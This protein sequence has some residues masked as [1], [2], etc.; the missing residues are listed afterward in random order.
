[1]ILPRADVRKCVPCVNVGY[2]LT[3]EL[4]AQ[5][6]GNQFTKARQ[7]VV[8]DQAFLP[9]FEGVYARIWSGATIP[10]CPGGSIWPNP[11]PTTPSRSHPSRPSAPPV[12]AAG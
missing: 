7:F 11:Q 10:R 1:M 3:S 6:F 2:N 4:H 9:C 5:S 12:P 8:I